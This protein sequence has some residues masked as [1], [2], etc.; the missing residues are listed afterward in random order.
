M[1]GVILV[2]SVILFLGLSLAPT[3]ALKPATTTLRQNNNGSYYYVAVDPN[4]NNGTNATIQYSGYAYQYKLFDNEIRN[5]TMPA[6]STHIANLK[7]A[8]PFRRI[9][10]LNTLPATGPIPDPDGCLDDDG[11]FVICPY[12]NLGDYHV[13]ASVV[14][15]VVKLNWLNYPVS[16]DNIL[17]YDDINNPDYDYRQQLLDFYTNE[18]DLNIRTAVTQSNCTILYDNV[19]TVGYT[20]KYGYHVGIECPDDFTYRTKLAPH[21]KFYPHV[22]EATLGITLSLE[23]N[24][25]SRT[26]IEDA[27]A[28]SGI[29]GKKVNKMRLT[30]DHYE[31]SLTRYEEVSVKR[32]GYVNN[33]YGAPSVTT[34]YVYN[35]TQCAGVWY[36]DFLDGAVDGKCIETSCAYMLN[37]GADATFILL[38][39]GLDFTHP[40]F[41]NN[42]RIKNYTVMA[43]TEISFT[44]IKPMTNS[45]NIKGVRRLGRS[46]LGIWNGSMVDLRTKKSNYIEHPTFDKF[47]HGT[48]IGAI[49]VGKTQGLAKNAQLYTLKAVKENGGVIEYAVRNGVDKAR[50]LAVALPKI[51]RKPIMVVTGINFIFDAE[52][53]KP[54]H[55][56]T[57]G[58]TSAVQ[59]LIRAGVS[60]VMPAGNGYM[61]SR[62]F[63]YQPPGYNIPAPFITNYDICH[64]ARY[65]TDVNSLV[66]PYYYPL[67]LITGKEITGFKDIK[68]FIITGF[69]HQLKQ[70]PVF[71]KV[72]ENGVAVTLDIN[73]FNYGNCVDYAAP[74]AGLERIA[75]MR[76]RVYDAY[77]PIG[78]GFC[79]HSVTPLGGLV[80]ESYDLSDNYTATGKTFPSGYKEQ[81]YTTTATSYATPIGAATIMSTLLQKWSEIKPTTVAKT[82]TFMT[83]LRAQIENLNVMP[84]VNFTMPAMNVTYNALANLNAVLGVFD[85][86]QVDYE[87]F[88]TATYKPIKMSK[89]V[90]TC[91]DY[92]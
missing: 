44:T 19:H 66:D 40:E 52:Q 69:D 5:W 39:S 65:V 57:V 50:A 2:I 91:V 75:V 81:P 67:Y 35:S 56:C 31:E 28:N 24:L 27:L 29:G 16:A 62:D 41:A 38:D 23:E 32:A 48:T 82:N 53:C 20:T 7:K 43:K 73:G 37:G 51:Q 36:K 3:S 46:Y 76:N 59:N 77:N 80:W 90:S 21:P 68:P 13:V 26:S 6:V 83:T 60:M 84:T 72:I 42:Q 61:N 92:K 74:G 25:S 30:E 14:D 15:V 22:M 64:W 9:V 45:E 55:K 33:T 86:E 34:G 88:K 63:C 79:F 71:K 10:D 89:V 87:K 12:S 78:D 8:I 58:L 85:K 1:K 17:P 49:L 11:N 47:G 70:T 54:L 4:A 18:T